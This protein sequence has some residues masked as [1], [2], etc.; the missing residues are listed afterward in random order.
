MAVTVV[1]ASFALRRN[2]FSSTHMLRQTPSKVTTPVVIDNGSAMMNDSSAFSVAQVL[3]RRAWW[4][5][6]ES[7]GLK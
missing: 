5:S 1:L 2:F 6:R 7:P 4:Q 3:K